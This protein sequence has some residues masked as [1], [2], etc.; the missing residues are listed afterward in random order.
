MAM[1]ATVWT[2]LENTM[3][4]EGSQSQK[5]WNRQSIETERLVV[6]SDWREGEGT[7]SEC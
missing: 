2:T 6:A 7:E 1:H 3:Q 4:R 5:V